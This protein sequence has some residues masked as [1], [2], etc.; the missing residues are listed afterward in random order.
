MITCEQAQTLAVGTKLTFAPENPK[1]FLA[2]SAT[3]TV[4]LIVEKFPATNKTISLDIDNFIT[5]GS[6][7]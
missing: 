4:R 5:P 7:S 1:H 3:L 6:A 2:T